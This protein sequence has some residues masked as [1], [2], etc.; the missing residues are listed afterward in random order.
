M[1][2]EIARDGATPAEKGEDA[3]VALEF[4]SLA[5]AQTACATRVATELSALEVFRPAK[6]APKV[7]LRVGAV[8]EVEDGEQGSTSFLAPRPA[9]MPI[10]TPATPTS[11]ST[12]SPRLRGRLR[13]RLVLS[14][15]PAVRALVARRRL[16][17]CSW[18]GRRGSRRHPSPPAWPHPGISARRPLARSC[19]HLG[20]DGRLA[21][22][23][24]NYDVDSVMHLPACRP[25]KSGGTTV[26]IDA[27]Q[28]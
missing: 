22:Q 23:T 2:A 26:M 17:V 4:S 13:C 9:R 24:A 12:G 25:S 14:R 15:Q 8:V 5:K 21:V 1:A 27:P 10:A 28:D 19:M 6:L 11:S 20:R 16:R 3:R 7:R 18:S